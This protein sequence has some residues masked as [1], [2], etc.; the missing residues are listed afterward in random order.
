MEIDLRANLVFRMSLLESFK[1]T[2]FDPNKPY[3]FFQD[4][5]VSPL[6]KKAMEREN[7]TDPDPGEVNE[8]YYQ[9]YST[10]V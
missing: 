5:E 3:I 9:H 10:H 4:R 7:S 6:P 1:K 2:T 8:H